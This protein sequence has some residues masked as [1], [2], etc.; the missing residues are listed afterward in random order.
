M[1]HIVKSGFGGSGERH[2]KNM[3]RACV[4][5]REKCY[6]VVPEQQ[7]VMAE[8]EMALILPSYAP[9]CFEVTNFK[10]FKNTVFRALGGLAG[11]YCDDVRQ[12]LIMWKTLS[13]LS[14]VL[15]MTR[16]T[17]VSA[18]LVSQ[19]LA[20]VKEMENLAISPDM[21]SLSGERIEGNAR[22][23][24]K[25]SDLTKIYS[26]Y[27]TLLCEKYSDESAA[28]GVILEKLR[29]NSG[30]LTD[31]KI[32]VSGF[33]S[34]T[35]GQY[36][37]LAALAKRTSVTLHLPIPKRSGGDFEYL[38]IS[39]AESKLK[40]AARRECVD[41]R[42]TE[43]D[44]NYT[45]QSELLSSLPRIIWK[46]NP[47]IDNSCLHNK[48][49]LRIFE[50][51][52]PFDECD[53]V[54]SDI[55][56]KVMGGAKYSDFAVIARSSEKYRGILD[57][58]LNAADV[59]Y[60]YSTRRDVTSF[61]AIKLILTAYSAVC[62][63]YRREDVITYAKCGFNGI[64]RED[65]D[66]LELYSEV[67]QINGATWTS[68]EPWGMNPAGYTSRKSP[69]T[70]EKLLRINETRSKLIS[71]LREFER[72]VRR[73]ST[74]RESA[75]A[76]MLFLI[77]V[78]LE[79]SLNARAEEERLS[80]NKAGA[81]ELSGLWRLIIDSLDAA[82]EVLG[83]LPATAEVFLSVLKAIFSSA[84]MGKIPAYS[85]QVTV[86]DA[87]MLRLSGKKHV[88]LIGVNQGEFPADVSDNSYFSDKDKLL[89]ADCGLEI[90][91]ELETQNAR[92]LFCFSRALAAASDSV[93][94][95]YS[96]CDTKFK[97]IEPSSVIEKIVNVTGGAVSPKRI[98][99]MPAEDRFFA[100]QSA[101][102]LS[103]T[104]SDS[105]Y[106][107]LEAALI[108]SGYENEIKVANSD[109]RNLSLNLDPSVAKELYRDKMSLTQTRIDSF[110]NCPLSYFLN[111]TLKLRTVAP[112]EFDASGIGA[113]IHGCLEH[114]FR[115]LTEKGQ[116]PSSLTKQ[117]REELT[118]IAAAKYL[119][120]MGENVSD[121]RTK[122]KINR[123]TRSAVPII[124]GLC[125]ELSKTDFRPRFFELKI[126]R[127][128]EDTPNP[129]T[130]TAS[131]GTEI[132]LYGVIDRV[133]T[134]KRGNDV[135]VK[136]IDYK[137]GS[138]EFSPEDL[139]KGRNLQMFLYLKAIT[140]TDNAAFRKKLGVEGDGKIIP[141]AA[142][143]VKTSLAD[144][145]V[146]KCS[147]DE[148]MSELMK[149]Q[150]RE[151]M[152]LGEEENLAAL[153][154]G[155]VPGTHKRDSQ[156]YLYTREGFE[157]IMSDVEESV[158][159]IAEEIKSGRAESR[160]N[161]TSSYNPCDFCDYKPICRNVV[162]KK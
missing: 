89:L 4:E 26:L 98:A 136:V 61:E 119:S 154:D 160:P 129:P 104:V 138:K 76:L 88:Y 151:G 156:K 100:A 48:D 60:F 72:D 63:G 117:R 69:D 46:I 30:F 157:E 45:T 84:N 36:R 150:L 125:D 126:D 149:K 23:T 86:G 124:D 53:F 135:Y 110:V 17:E 127:R 134:V 64:S 43:E 9:L 132:Y 15:D 66:E 6:L 108:R 10:R 70:A 77:S 49:E 7:T 59:P 51:N 112:A 42:I 27:K 50:A 41:V 137:T 81:D 162:L 92:E 122:V 128:S 140:D 11:E 103:D 47:I 35:E 123:L 20:A 38:E 39:R 94:L 73:A 52:D 146:N 153:G 79:D 40:G 24:S 111:Y 82:V 62:H 14:P 147:D 145:Q 83:D 19:A 121:T 116:D 28:D 31:A 54:A 34:F 57:G 68:D 101:L 106:K 133:D 37:L 75:E 96:V 8:S 3:I 141:A 21:L 32:F 87:D 67:W 120:D 114:F 95:L 56:R 13:E 155:Y 18:G 65:V 107:A 142:V 161:V 118:R 144:V 113:F 33:T 102:S 22:L 97:R 131:D 91:P 44:G 139:K 74:V 55:R 115:D 5:K 93:T 58:A 99:D 148:A 2:L 1:L 25:I 85:D 29:E 90:S 159:R 105:E 109:I 80:G 158:V 152:A 143:Y 12:S 130:F 78:G 71:P 16:R